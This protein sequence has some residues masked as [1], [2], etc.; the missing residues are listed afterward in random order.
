MESHLMTIND[1]SKINYSTPKTLQDLNA[2]LI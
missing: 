1:E 2:L